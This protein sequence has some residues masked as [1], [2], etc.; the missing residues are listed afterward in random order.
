MNSLSFP[1]TRGAF[2][3]VRELHVSCDSAAGLVNPPLRLSST[4]VHLRIVSTPPVLQQTLPA[5]DD[6]RRWQTHQSTDKRIFP[7]HYTESPLRAILSR[8]HRP[9]PRK[10]NRPSVSLSL[11]T[12]KP[13]IRRSQSSL[14]KVTPE[15]RLPPTRAAP[16]Q[17]IDPNQDS[18][19]GNYLVSSTYAFKTN[20]LKHQSL[21]HRKFDP[22]SHPE[23]S[24]LTAE[25]HRLRTRDTQYREALLRV[26]A[27]LSK[28]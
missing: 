15:Q 25:H 1:D 21:K 13:L 2:R 12:E 19:L 18:Q 7:E 16:W 4:P 6:I 24:Q 17:Q 10:L 8:M 26:K 28:S 20:W 5:P 11:P 9:T 22:A 27:M 14:L 23:F 3:V